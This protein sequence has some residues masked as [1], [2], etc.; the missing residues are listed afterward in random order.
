MTTRVQSPLILGIRHHGP[1]SARSVLRA[2]D[3][4]QPDCVLVEGPPDAA[5]VLPLL[6]NETMSP[7][8]ALLIY[9]PEMPRR[10]VYYPLAIFSP[11]WQ[12][13]QYCLNRNVPVRFMDLPQA[14]QFGLRQG[15]QGGTKVA[16]L[17]APL[18]TP[19]PEEGNSSTEATPVPD[20]ISRADPLGWL[21]QAAGYADGERW[22]E[23]MVEERRDSRD[24][25]AGIME[26]MTTLRDVAPPN[27]DKID[28][29]RE[30]FMRQT[31]RAAQR[32][33][34]ARIAVVCGAW[35]APALATLPP[36]KEDDTLLKGLPK[37]SV[38]ATW[39]P[40]THS[41][42][43]FQSGYGAGI[44]SPGWYH[45]LWTTPE[46]IA[47]RWL[48]RVAHLLREQDLDAS[49]AHI[50][51]GARLAETLA[52]LRGRPLPGLADLNEAVQAVF[53]FG[54]D[55]QMR[56]IHDKL[57][58]GE[59]LGEVPRETPRTP[60][61]QDF[62]REQRRLKLKLE[63]SFRDVD[64]DLRQPTDLARS[65]LLHRLNLLN[66]GWGTHTQTGGSKHGTFH[67]L[68]RLQ[69]KPEFEIALIEAGTWGNT[70]VDAAS[71]LAL[72][73]ADK[74]PNLPALTALLDRVLLA[75]LPSATAHLM[76]CIQDEAALASDVGHLMGALPHLIDV[77][78][79]GDV[80]KTDNAM[81]AHVV[82]GLVARICIG[83][84]LACASLNDEAATDT[85]A[86]IVAVNHGLS[87][88]HN[89]EHTAS[90]HAALGKLA[91]PH[92]VHGLVA[93]RCCRLLLDAGALE[94]GE[95]ARR[96]GLA[97]SKAVE[98]AAAAAWIEGFLKDSGL[99]LLH[100]HV[101]WGVFDTWLVTLSTET[102]A[103]L[104]TLLRRTF[105]TFP[106][107]QRRQMGDLAR[108]GQVVTL[109]NTTKDAYFDLERAEAALPL[110]ALLLGVEAR[111]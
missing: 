50:I 39:V 66:V 97:L 108:R 19:G 45:H 100:D 106:G 65:Q 91:V 13:I 101:L 51:E 67:E 17:E 58:V 95:V 76:A 32:E 110:L 104:V 11:E 10:A 94:R 102:F 8:V 74:A 40:W 5:D 52:A 47:I 29:L 27:Q 111:G 80:R 48:T 20:S 60:V 68:W 18:P 26:A 70:V 86:N 63:A 1:G 103:A 35:H 84:P 53:C 93:G 79:Y 83:L 98:P 25:F 30:P 81:V 34:F 105:S 75:D 59:T 4:W 14:H 2:L 69:W 89:G 96:L 57:I 31:I 99:I 23:H 28:A 87:I 72:D 21:A 82:D 62:L 16:E 90:W 12:T 85:F 37:V 77:L 41:R 9:A 24:L 71:A 92:G 3:E 22:W 43:A 109:G 46:H 78:C 64:L 88:L 38:E 107:P 42:L 7:P 49:S 15:E 73:G 55:L 61:Q 54:D 44:E 56:L 33:G 6:A 36:A